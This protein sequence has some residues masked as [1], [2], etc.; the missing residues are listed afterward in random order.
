MIKMTCLI[1]LMA[2]TF[3][4][5]SQSADGALEKNDNTLEQRYRL[6]KDKSETFNEYKV[7]KEYILD[8]M[9]KITRDSFKVKQADLA[10]AKTEINDL[11]SELNA[12]LAAV[13]QK[14]ESMEEIVYASSHIT[15]L[16]IDF[17]KGMFITTVAFT[18][19]GL[20]LVIGLI[21]GKLKLMYTSL[22]EKIELEDSVSKEFEN[23]KRKA[24]E[25]QMKLSRE[26]QDERNRL[27]EVRGVSAH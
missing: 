13:K 19:L 15:V 5:F 9:W 2:M 25:K 18:V 23:Y 14:E 3:T 21:T 7:I 4:G 11:K 16:G 12:A 24:L 1:A 6:M 27:A 17:T 20:L 26:L 8:G 22:R 10:A